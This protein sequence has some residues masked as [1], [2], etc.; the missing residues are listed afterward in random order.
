[1]SSRWNLQRPLQEAEIED[2]QRKII[3]L[4]QR[5]S[6]L[7]RRKGTECVRTDDDEGISDNQVSS[8]HKDALKGHLVSLPL[9][10]QSSSASK[11]LKIRF[12]NHDDDESKKNAQSEIFMHKAMNELAITGKENAL[13]NT[14]D[15]ITDFRNISGNAT[16]FIESN[17]LSHGNQQLG[18]GKKTCSRVQCSLCSGV[19]CAFR[20]STNGEWV[21]AFC[22]E[23][24]LESTY[25]RCQQNLVEKMEAILKEK[26]IITC[27][28][29]HNRLGLVP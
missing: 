8:T 21:H 16:N 27:C 15:V 29:C 11:N 12:R 13:Q 17:T 10:P 7:E 9:H 23:W 26:D 5:L 25:K 14:S 19:T 28:I 2:L 20:K 3:Q 6:R 1:M 22:A 4:Q 18:R 24:L